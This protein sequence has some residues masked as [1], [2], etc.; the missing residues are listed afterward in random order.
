[1]DCCGWPETG[2]GRQGA[3]AGEAKVRRAVRI[4]RTAQRV[5]PRG[6]AAD[7]DP[8]QARR[9]VSRRGAV[10]WS[11]SFGAASASAARPSSSSAGP[12]TGVIGTAR[13]PV[14][15]LPANCPVERPSCATDAPLAVRSNTPTKSANAGAPWVITVPPHL[16][17]G[18]WSVS[19]RHRQPLRV[20]IT[21][22]RHGARAVGSLELWCRCDAGA[23]R[24][25]VHHEVVF[26]AT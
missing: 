11:S 3:H 23:I 17:P 14:H 10:R 18:S 4:G 2:G 9:R 8:P 26:R 25:Q 5:E 15:R 24:R 19:L 20:G 13:E 12:A 7:R 1:M 16:S 22:F 21:T 6:L